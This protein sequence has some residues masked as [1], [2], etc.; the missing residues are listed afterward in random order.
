MTYNGRDYPFS[1]RAGGRFRHVEAEMMSAELSGQVLNLKNLG[2]F[3]GR[4][5]KI[6][7]EGGSPDSGSRVSMK[8]QRGVV[9]TVVSP[10]EGRKF[11]LTREGMEVELKK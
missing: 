11:D 10:V 3:S 9:V 8:N 5:H 2:D 4:Y 1:Y 7:T 6:E